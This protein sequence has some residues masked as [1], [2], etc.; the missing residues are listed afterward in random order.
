MTEQAI[1]KKITDKLNKSGWFVVKL[2]KTNVNGVTDLIACKAA[3]CVWIEVKKQGGKLS[4]LQEFTIKQMRAKGL[5]VIVA[6]G[7]EDIKE[8]I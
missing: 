5:S 1:Q 8:L 6:Y 2:I 3:R 4:K 7:I